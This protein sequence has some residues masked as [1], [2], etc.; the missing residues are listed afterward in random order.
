MTQS[1]QNVHTPWR[2]LGF[3]V[4]IGIMGFSGCIQQIGPF[5]PDGG[6]YASEEFR[7]TYSANP[8]TVLKVY[9]QNGAITV[10][11]WDNEQVE[12]YAFK[13]TQYGQDELDKVNIE[14]STGNEMTVKSQFSSLGTMEQIRFPFWTHRTTACRCQLLCSF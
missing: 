4:I 11:S 7:Q 10:T 9:N 1:K 2:I 12:V 14:V 13:E 8:G 3:L 5:P 6:D